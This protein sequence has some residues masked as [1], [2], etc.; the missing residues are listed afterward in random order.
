MILYKKSRPTA[1][2]KKKIFCDQ[3]IYGTTLN[4]I[5][6]IPIF[7]AHILLYP[8]KCSQPLVSTMSNASGHYLIE[9]IPAGVYRLTASK[10]GYYIFRAKCAIASNRQFSAIDIQLLRKPTRNCKGKA[11]DKRMEYQS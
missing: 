10:P 5:T 11:R 9:S 2:A 1:K 8:L 7:N 4:P 3:A 6:Q